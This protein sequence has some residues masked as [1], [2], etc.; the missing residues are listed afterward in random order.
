MQKP[1]HFMNVYEDIH[2]SNHI[3]TDSLF[4]TATEAIDDIDRTG[5]LNHQIRTMKGMDRYTQWRLVGTYAAIRGIHDPSLLVFQKLT[6]QELE[7]YADKEAVT[8][9]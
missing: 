6:T 5:K 8:R 4:E 9:E 7:K 3:A 1:T 2:N